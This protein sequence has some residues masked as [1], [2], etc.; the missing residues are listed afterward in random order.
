MGYF[1][2]ECQQVIIEE[3]HKIPNDVIHSL[4]GSMPQRLASE[5]NAKDANSKYKTFYVHILN[6]IIFLFI[7]LIFQILTPDKLY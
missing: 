2:D 5:I 4:Y 7:F 6:M 1:E 3:W